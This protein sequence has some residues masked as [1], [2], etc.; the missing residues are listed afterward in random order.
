MR[1][2]K[3]QT[4]TQ[5]F[6][7]SAAQLRMRQRVKRVT[8][9]IALRLRTKYGVACRTESLLRVRRELSVRSVLSWTEKGEE[10]KMV[11]L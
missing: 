1:S 2:Q 9:T 5:R 11:G 10:E 6:N 8:W 4:N 7:S 3:D